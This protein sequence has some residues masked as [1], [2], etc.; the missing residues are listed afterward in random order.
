VGWVDLLRDDPTRLELE[1]AKAGTAP[2]YLVRDANDEPVLRSTMRLLKSHDAKLQLALQ[3]FGD[4]GHP[5]PR[6]RTRPIVIMVDG[7]PLLGNLTPEWGELPSL[8]AKPEN[9]PRGPKELGIP[10]REMWWIIEKHLENPR[11]HSRHWLAEQTRERHDLDFVPRTRLSPLVD[12][13]DSRPEAARH[14]ARLRVIPQE[15]RAGAL[16]WIPPS[17]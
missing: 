3:Y 2:K 12:W 10:E 6:E 16:G 14:A 1:L 15:F 5:Q 4:E 8:D 7:K 9:E 11:K 13:V 17:T